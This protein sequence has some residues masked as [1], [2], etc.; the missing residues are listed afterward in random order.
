M[1]N[2]RL[3]AS[4]LLALA[5]Q[6]TAGSACAQGIGGLIKKKA[7]EVAKGKAP[8]STQGTANPDAAQPTGSKLPKTLTEVT[9]TAFKKGLT[10]ERDHRQVTVKFLATLPSPD[11]YQACRAQV[12]A[13]P[14]QQKIMM[15]S[16]GGLPENPTQEQLQ[17][18][19]EKMTADGTKLLRDKCGENPNDYNAGWKDK[20]MEE[21]RLAGAKAFSAALG[22][23]SGSAGPFLSVDDAQPDDN[24]FY[25]L[26][27]EWTPPFCNLSKEAQQA[28]ADKGVSVPGQGKGLAYVYTAM[29]ARLLM[30]QCE[31]LMMLLNVLQ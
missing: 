15:S 6:S 20:K 12:A 23:S 11:Q 8:Q 18:A 9:V 26:L 14:E 4:F 2:T 28:A 30:P 7:G 17:K 21:A 16:L 31:E 25:Q 10:V 5:A 27:K 22:G 19:S 13:S 24:Y 29:E 1:T 3:V